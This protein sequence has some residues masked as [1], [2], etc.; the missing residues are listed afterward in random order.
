MKTISLCQFYK[1]IPPLENESI[2][3][4]I[5]DPIIPYYTKCCLSRGVNNWTKRS[6]KYFRVYGKNNIKQLMRSEIA[7]NERVNF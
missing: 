6:G 4:H 5:E 1:Q 2:K 3:T 7:D